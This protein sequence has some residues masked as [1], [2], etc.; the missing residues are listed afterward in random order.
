MHKSPNIF[1]S[2][3]GDQKQKKVPMGTE[4]HL[5]GC[6]G[7]AKNYLLHTKISLPLHMI[8]LCESNNLF[9]IHISMPKLCWGAGDPVLNQL[10]SPTKIFWFGWSLQKRGK[11]RHIEP[12]TKSA[13]F[14]FCILKGKTIILGGLTE[15]EGTE[16]WIWQDQKSV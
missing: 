10:R 2:Q 14:V 1:G 6:L 5:L 16:Q 15:F 7:T 8:L 3:N 13:Y 12:C 9:L 11:S 4:G